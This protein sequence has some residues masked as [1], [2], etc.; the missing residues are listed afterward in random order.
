MSVVSALIHFLMSLV[1]ALVR[2]AW[3]IISLSLRLVFALSLAT[4][5]AIRPNRILGMRR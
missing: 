1:T 5:G 2:I 3:L 4:L